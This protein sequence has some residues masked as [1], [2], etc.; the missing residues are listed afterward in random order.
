[1]SFMPLILIQRNFIPV[2]CKKIISNKIK[3][4][5]T[6]EQATKVQEGVDV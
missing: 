5:V 6:L 1:M 2:S 4:K 3:V